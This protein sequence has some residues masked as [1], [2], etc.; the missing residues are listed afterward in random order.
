MRWFRFYAEVADDPKV[1][2]L[3]DKQFKQWVM[4]LCIACKND[5]KLPC[6]EDVAYTLRLSTLDA[7]KMLINFI[8]KGLLE[9][10]NDG[11]LRPHNWDAR[12]FQSD[13]S[14]KR[15]QAFRERK[16]QHS[17]TVHETV[18]E[19][20][21]ETVTKRPRARDTDTDTDTEYTHVVP[22]SGNG[23]LIEKYDPLTDAQSE[24]DAV[25]ER[26]K[27]RHAANYRHAM[28]LN[29]IRVEWMSALAKR[30]DDPLAQACIIDR[31]HE[32]ACS[33]DAWSGK[34]REAL[35]KWL[36][37]SGYMDEYP[38]PVEE[39]DGYIDGRQLLRE[40]EALN[41]QGD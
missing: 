21:Q 14:T 40:Q 15:V 6:D 11:T 32:R 22:I 19:T 27:N 25:L 17:E 23:N 33:T 36:S 18:S 7:R 2:R 3:P 35:H 10:S 28:Q 20:F 12:Q 26:I 39:T 29:Q 31:A 1:C 13:V 9:R 34:Y 37:R 16:K 8:D 5:G 41:A 24:C 30:L 4:L 38:D